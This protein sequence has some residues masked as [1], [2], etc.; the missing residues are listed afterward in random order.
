MA[1]QRI[2]K[3]AIN[4]LKVRSG[5]NEEI[6]AFITAENGLEERLDRLAQPMSATGS[7]TPR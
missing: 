3:R 7:V 1:T 4:G 5:T 6:A 2:T